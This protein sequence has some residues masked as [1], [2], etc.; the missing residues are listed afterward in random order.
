MNNTIETRPPKVRIVLKSI[1][2]VLLCLFF[3][4]LLLFTLESV[5]TNGGE[6][7][8]SEL[9]GWCDQSYRERNYPE[10]YEMLTLYD[11]YDADYDLYWEAVRAYTAYTDVVEWSRAASLGTEGAQKRAQESLATLQNLAAQPAFEQN[12]SLARQL[13]EAAQAELSPQENN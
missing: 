5:S 7:T 8:K 6:V 2:A 9:I 1:A 3:I 13:L 12:T 11:L 4:Q 10:L